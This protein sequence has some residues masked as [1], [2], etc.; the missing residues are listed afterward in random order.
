MQDK[1]I[2]LGIANYNK[3]I[4]IT[5]K[6][7]Q[8]IKQGSTWFNQNCWDDEYNYGTQPKK[9]TLPKEWEGYY[10]ENGGYEAW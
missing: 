8:Y 4:K 6:D 5:K 9:N 10:D 2:E 3:Y 7:Y 1:D